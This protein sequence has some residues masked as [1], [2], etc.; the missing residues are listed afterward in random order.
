MN[1]DKN[2]D[3]VAAQQLISP[4]ILTHQKMSLNLRKQFTDYLKLKYCNNEKAIDVN[5]QKEFEVIVKYGLIQAQNI[6]FSKTSTLLHKGIPPRKDVW[7]KLGRIA[8]EFLNYGSYPIIPSQDLT[9][10]INKSLGVRCLRVIK[11]YRK[12]VLLYCGKSESVIDRCADSR[13]GELDVSFFVIQIP[14]QYR[15]TS[16]TSS[17][18]EDEKH[19]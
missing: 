16:S 9:K 5:E 8:T 19:D 4:T 2:D 3:D 17:F 11:D 12:T 13:F 6:L 15:I 7:E 18:R 14:A 1:L 10:I